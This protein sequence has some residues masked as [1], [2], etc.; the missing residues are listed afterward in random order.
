MGLQALCLFWDT[1]TIA[2]STSD[3]KYQDLYNWILFLLSMSFYTIVIIPLDILTTVM[4]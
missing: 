4:N 3:A 1:V 2:S